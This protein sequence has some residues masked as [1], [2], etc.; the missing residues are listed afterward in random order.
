MVRTE[1]VRE[2]INDYQSAVRANKRNR[3]AS[4]EAAVNAG[5]D[6]R[7]GNRVSYYIVGSDPHQRSF[8]NARLYDKDTKDSERVQLLLLSKEIR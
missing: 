7:P 5:L 8:S 6:L 1:T 2:S 4:F 3:T